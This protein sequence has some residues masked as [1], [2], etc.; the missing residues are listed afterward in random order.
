MF[1]TDGALWSL[2]NE[3]WYYLL[4]PLGLITCRRGRRWRERAVCGGLFLVTAAFVRGNI[5]ASFPIWLAGVALLRLKAPA[6]PGR[7]GRT[8][9][10]AATLV[11]FPLL[12]GLSRFNALPPLASDYLLTALTLLYLWLLLSDRT[13]FRAEALEVRGSREM[14]RFSYTL[15]A[16]HTP[17]L[18]LAASLALGDTRW[19]PSEPHAAVRRW[20]DG[21]S[22]A[23]RLRGSVRDGVQD[24]CGSDA[25]GTAA[26]MRVEKPALP[27]DTPVER[28]LA[29]ES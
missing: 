6:F 22:F 11:Y 4:F 9:R 7:T 26:R 19:Y 2:A 24:G 29:A 14:A 13:R 21:G 12:I 28:G 16:T 20:A 18:V 10:V 15:Y 8:V 23:L 27:A 3:F 5:L 17:V 25:V 1:G